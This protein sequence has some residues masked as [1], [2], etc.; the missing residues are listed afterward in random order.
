MFHVTIVGAGQLGSRHLQA[1]KAVKFP[2]N[3]QVVDISDSSL[4]IAQERYHAVPTQTEHQISFNK[5]FEKKESTDLAIVATNSNIRR[6]ALE[7]L[8]ESSHCSFIVLEKLLFD[9]PEDYAAIE[10]LLAEKKS[11]AWV[12]CP[13]R[14]MPVYERIRSELQKKPIEYRVSGSQFGLITNAIHYLDH[15]AHLTGSDDFVLDTSGLDKNPIESKRPG[16]LELNGTLKARFADG[17]SCEISCYPVGTAPVV[18]TIFNHQNR[19]FIKESERL[20][21]ESSVHSDW[22]WTEQPADI[23]YQS[24]LTTAMVE[25]FIN[26]KTCALTPY[27]QSKKIHL[28]LLEPLLNFIQSSMH[29][30]KHYPFT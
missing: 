13:M 7:T 4:K 8:L 9:K 19:Y 29:T 18:V 15:M 10:T 24:T 28:Q 23:P 25:S 3:I 20:V 5:Q 21:W 30:T 6:Q 17:S 22:S 16:F 12:N 1:L 14:M 2:L 27:R 26:H 11:Q